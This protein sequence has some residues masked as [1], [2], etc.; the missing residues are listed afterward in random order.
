VISEK[1]EG[2][3][4]AVFDGGDGT[5][6]DNG[7]FSGLCL[8]GEPSEPGSGANLDDQKAEASGVRPSRRVSA[9][10]DIGRILRFSTFGYIAGVTLFALLQIYNTLAIKGLSRQN[11]QLR[12]RLRIST[13]ISTAQELKVSELQSIHNITQY[14]LALGLSTSSVPPV[15]IDTSKENDKP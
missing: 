5:V 15:E 6:L 13:S 14:A 12:E 4:R 1:N 10:F 7:G 2:T 11:E 3:P 9:P 8:P